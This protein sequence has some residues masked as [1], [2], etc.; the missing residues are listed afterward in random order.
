MSQPITLR[1]VFES[2]TGRQIDK[3]AHYFPVYE[4]HFERFRRRPIRLLEIGIDHGGSLQLWK[5]YFGPMAEI[6]GIDI[7]PAA[8]FEEDQI[9]TYCHNQRASIIADLGPFD[10]II[11]DGSHDPEDQAVTFEHLWPRTRGVYLI[12]DCHRQY[13]IL[14]PQVPLTYNYPWVIVMERPQRM[15]RGTPSRDL[16]PDEAEARKLYGA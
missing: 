15:I 5:Q 14:T 3:W 11:D 12:E 13:P 2:H 6:I 7:D 4:R 1:G 16:R 8:M 10:I 9:K